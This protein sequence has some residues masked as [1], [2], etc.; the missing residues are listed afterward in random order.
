MLS[1]NRYAWNELVAR[2]KGRW[3]RMSRKEIDTELRPLLK[4]G[5]LVQT[6]MKIAQ[7]PEDCFDSAYREFLTSCKTIKALSKSKKNSTGQGFAYPEALRFKTKKQGGVKIEIRGR[8]VTYKPEER[9]IYFY[10]KYFDSDNGIA[11]KTD[12]TKIEGL[13]N[14]DYSIR[15]CLRN[16]HYYFMIPRR[17]ERKLPAPTGTICALDP[18]VRTFMSGYDPSGCCF[19]LS[20]N[21]GYLKKRQNQIARLQSS[22]AKEKNKNTRRRL[23]RQINDL[24]R[25]INNCVDDL[26]HKT[27]KMLAD[28]YSKILLP[29]FETS[30]MV[31]KEKRKIGRA[32]SH[33]MLTLSHYKFRMLLEHKMKQRSGQLITC[34]EEYTSKTCGQCG[35]LNHAL[36]RDKIFIC[37]Y[38][39]CQLRIDRDLNGARNIFIKNY[40]SIDMHLSC[41]EPPGIHPIIS[42]A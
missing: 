20:P 25:K 6:R 38:N 21:Q 29:T 9:K 40:N 4:K 8:S 17:V 15:L 18:G 27:T 41:P 28:S 36:G 32:T 5:Y 16:G 23:K 34:S 13:D 26:H 19:E 37:P 39:D 42:L 35:R 33:D 7:C 31:R 11:I 30:E 14:F 1:A 3:H 2:T 24:Y 12:L 22:M 10:P